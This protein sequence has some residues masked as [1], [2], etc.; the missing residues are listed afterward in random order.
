MDV[1]VINE[2]VLVADQGGDR[3]QVY[4]LNGN[5]LRSVTF[6]GVAGQN[7]NW[8][9]GVCEIPGIPP[10]TKIQA[11]SKD[12]LGRLHVLDNFA[13][14][15]MIF[16]PTDGAYIAAYGGYGTDAGQLRVPMD[17]KILATDMA[18]VTPGDGD[19]VEIFATP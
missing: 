17:V 10:F 1:E 19:R 3:V 16:D 15:V 13:A 7:C 6:E 8:F 12:S 14:S 5:W 11:L 2:E 9:T 4:D 18:I